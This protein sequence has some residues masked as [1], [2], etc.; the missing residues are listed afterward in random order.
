[1]SLVK[2]TAKVTDVYPGSSA[3]TF[4]LTVRTVHLPASP[5]P[6]DDILTLDNVDP[7]IVDAALKT[8]IISAVKS[9]WSLGVLDLVRVFD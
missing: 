4:A 9:R 2:A 3:N 7:D 8:D 5:L 1:M 6:V